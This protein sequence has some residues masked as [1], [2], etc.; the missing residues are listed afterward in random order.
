MPAPA[1]ALTV[2]AVAGLSGDMMLAGLVRMNNLTQTELDA[3]VALLGFADLRGRI[4]IEQRSV[5]AVNGWSCAVELPHEHAHRSLADIR[6]LIGNCGLSEPAKQLSLDCFSLLAGAEG[7]VHGKAPDTVHFHEVGA[8][9]SIVDICLACS[10]FCRLNPGN[11]VCSPLPLADGGVHCAHGWLP[12]P[13]PAVLQL[14]EN[15]PVCGFAGRGETVTPTALALLKTLGAGFG[16]WP[17][18]LVQRRALVYGTKVFPDVP[19][20]AIW[21]FGPERRA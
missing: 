12:T 16:P 6:S 7:A 19:N 9:D 1:T 4:R 5:H 17:D 21:A 2:R 11:F 8:L 20:G 13:A 10:L 15:V 18:M 14:L 3:E